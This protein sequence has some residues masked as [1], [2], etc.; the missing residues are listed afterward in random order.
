MLHYDQ[1]KAFYV[2]FFKFDFD[3]VFRWEYVIFRFFISIFGVLGPKSYIGDPI[4]PNL[5]LVLIV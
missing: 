1:F 5:V 4:G 3:F 2:I